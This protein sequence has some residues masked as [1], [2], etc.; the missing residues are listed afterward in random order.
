MSPDDSLVLAFD[1]VNDISSGDTLISAVWSITVS[2]GEDDLVQHRLQGAPFLFTPPDGTLQT[3]TMQRVGGLQPG[4]LYC[5]KATV[6][7]N[8]TDQV[9][10]WAGVYGE[11]VR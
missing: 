5:V 9:S 3:A 6:I 8:D 4:V 7:V 11:A 1:F 2:E 10:L